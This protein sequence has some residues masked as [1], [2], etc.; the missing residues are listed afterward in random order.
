MV[1]P[2]EAKTKR[3]QNKTIDY[4]CVFVSV[5]I[6][7]YICVYLLCLYFVYVCAN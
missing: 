7:I 2:G 1:V 6:Y 3:N 4:S 5:Y